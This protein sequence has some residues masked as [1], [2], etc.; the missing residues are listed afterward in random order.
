MKLKRSLQALMIALVVIPC[1]LVMS[2][3]TS[4]NDDEHDIRGNYTLY[5][6]STNPAGTGTGHVNHVQNGSLT[7]TPGNAAA[8]H[9]GRTMLT[10]SDD[11]MSFIGLP[12]LVDGLGFQVNYVTTAPFTV[13]LFELGGQE[14]VAGT[15]MV[16]G[17]IRF[18]LLQVST[19]V[20]HHI[21]IWLINTDTQ[22]SHQLTFAKA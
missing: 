5:S 16:A 21:S 10:V 19:S 11:K 1:V 22:I 20:G 7:A 3:C 14:L 13:A 6:Y 15:S 12:V 8:G 9:L 2:A 4:S 17:N 18:S